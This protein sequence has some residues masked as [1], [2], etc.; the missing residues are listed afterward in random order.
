MLG[1]WRIDTDEPHTLCVPIKIDLNSVAID[2][3]FNFGVC[4]FGYIGL[5]ALW[6]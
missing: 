5:T 2:N 6:W 3:F 1:L 4:N